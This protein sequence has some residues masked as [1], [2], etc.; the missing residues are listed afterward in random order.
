M[1][2]ELVIPSNHLIFCRPLLLLPSVFPSIRVFSNESILCISGQSIGVSASASL[3][4]M[5]IQDWFPLG[6]TGW[7]SLQMRWLLMIHNFYQT[8]S[9]VPCVNSFPSQRLLFLSMLL[10]TIIVTSSPRTYW[11]LCQGHT[12][13]CGDPRW[14]ISRGR[15]GGRQPGDGDAWPWGYRDGGQASD[16]DDKLA[17]LS[18]LPR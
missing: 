15:G 18:W 16:I 2:I 5:N 6:W 13:R 8:Q 7:I 17:Q 3:L 11:F 12:A 9:T 10:V 4:P 14:G 1:S